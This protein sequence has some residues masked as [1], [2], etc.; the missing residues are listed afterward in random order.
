MKKLFPILLVLVFGAA[1]VFT[2]CTKEPAEADPLPTA[3]IEGKVEVRNDLTVTDNDK[4][5]SGTKIY[6]RINSEDLVLDPLADYAYQTLQYETTVKDG[7]YKIELPCATHKNI[8]VTIKPNEYQGELR[9]SNDKKQNHYF[10][11][12][13]L[14]MSIRN[15]E[16]HFLDILYQ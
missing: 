11:A 2:S 7:K 14:T 4:A 5:P 1:T 13:T 15:G 6:F 16:N 10:D 12:S 3:T 8:T 9:I